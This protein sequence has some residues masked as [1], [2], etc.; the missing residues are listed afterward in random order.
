MSVAWV[1]LYFELNSFAL[2]NILLVKKLSYFEKK[3]ATTSLFRHEYF[4]E[5]WYKN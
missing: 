3:V 1:E 4:C 5:L 2:E